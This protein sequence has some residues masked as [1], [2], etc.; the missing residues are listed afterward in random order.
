MEKGPKPGGGWSHVSDLRPS[1]GQQCPSGTRHNL[2]FQHPWAGQCLGLEEER[3]GPSLGTAPG[4]A[5]C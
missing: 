2:F 4:D 5:L 3:E 1:P